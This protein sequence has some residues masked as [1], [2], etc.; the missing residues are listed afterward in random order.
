[1]RSLA[2]LEAV[3]LKEM[4]TA[5]EKAQ[6][7]KATFDGNDVHQCLYGQAT[8]VCTSPR[9][10]ELI[11][12]CCE[13]VYYVGDVEKR[14]QG[15]LN[16]SPTKYSVTPIER[17]CSYV[18]PIECLIFDENGGNKAG[19]KIIDFIQGKTDQLKL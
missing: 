13:K 8:G 1:M 7:D 4:L 6:L 11:E 14:S 15:E 3:K 9:A 16:G 5:E 17:I 12:A 19:C 2:T 10:K 18:S